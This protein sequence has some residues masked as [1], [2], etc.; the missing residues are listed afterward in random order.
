MGLNTAQSPLVYK[1]ACNSAAASIAE[2]ARGPQLQPPNAIFLDLKG[3]ISVI[4]T[5]LRK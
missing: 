5:S 4:R 2:P 1:L 3:K